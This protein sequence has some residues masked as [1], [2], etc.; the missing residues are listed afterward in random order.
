MSK[1]HTFQLSGLGKAP[2]KVVHPKQHAAEKGSI[3]WCEHC[4]TQIKNRH[5]IKSADG[6]VSIVGIDCLKKTGDQGLVDGE[7][8][9]KRQLKNEEREARAVKDK[10]AR[11]EEER[12][13][14]NGL[15]KAQVRDNLHK[16]RE[17]L[18]GLHVGNILDHQVMR[19][20]S[21]AGFETDMHIQACSGKPYSQG[22]LS[23][24]KEI[25]AKKASGSR[26]NSKKYKEAYETIEAVVNQF[27]AILVSHWQKIEEL[28][29]QIRAL[30][31]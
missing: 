1:V 18:L 3:F 28:K 20:L 14:Y 13:K 12:A 25:C 24:I 4:G 2:F 11:E 6:K 8:R 10:E 9:L 23:V 7:R 31:Y 15:T 19:F 21:R 30:S 29:D 16:E 5:F 22:Q 17:N 27:Q 26:K